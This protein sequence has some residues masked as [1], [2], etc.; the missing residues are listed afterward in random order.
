MRFADGWIL[1]GDVGWNFVSRLFTVTF[2]RRIE[3]NQG[4]VLDS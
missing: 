4:E 2:Y 1:F 3:S